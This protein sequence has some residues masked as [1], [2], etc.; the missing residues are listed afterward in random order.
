ML[1]LAT[2][3][4][5]AVGKEQLTLKMN[6]T[7]SLQVWNVKKQSKNAVDVPKEPDVSTTEEK[8]SEN[9]EPGKEVVTALYFSL[10]VT[11]LPYYPVT[12]KKLE[13]I[14]ITLFNKF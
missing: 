5:I 14:L 8:D 12:Q 6:Y 10:I 9:H 4:D 1:D 13:L 11:Y 7:R 3:S 2:S